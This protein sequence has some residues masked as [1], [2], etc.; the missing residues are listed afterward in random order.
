ML[1][2]LQ[3]SFSD[4]IFSSGDAAAT[5]IVSGKL[6]AAGRLAIY[7]HNVF[8]NLRGALREIF[9]VI[10]RIVGA[11]FF[12]HAADQFI[13][14]TPST[15]GDLNQFGREWPAFLAAYPH[16]QE[17]PYLAD[18]ARLEWAWHEC[19]HAADA[20]MFDINRLAAIDA[21]DHGALIFTLHPALRLLSSDYPLM[22]I[23]RINQPGYVGEMIV[24]WD[25]AGEHL[26]VRRDTGADGAIGVVIESLSPAGWRFL[27]ALKDRCALEIAAADALA[28][29]ENFDLQNFLISS[30]QS[31]IVTDV[32]TEKPG[33]E[34]PPDSNGC[35]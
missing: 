12:Q 34:S 19:F 27:D 14:D 2:D 20:P 25:Q 30:V 32:E 18:V 35:E 7:R 24:D 13:R 31:G 22:H 33:V 4:A 15:S 3:H 28:I 9:P 29:D 10:E 8:A 6:S 23:W 17:L 21:A 5:S 1:R 16:A 26:L 11:A